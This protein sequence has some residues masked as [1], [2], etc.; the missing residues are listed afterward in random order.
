MRSRIRA[1]F[2]KPARS[3]RVV[4]V[5]SEGTSRWSK[6]FDQLAAV[7][8]LELLVLYTTNRA[9][10]LTSNSKRLHAS[11]TL[12]EMRLEMINRALGREYPVTWT[13]WRALL[14]L[15]PDCVLVFGWS[16]FAAQATLTWCN[17]L[18]I[19]YVLIVDRESQTGSLS[20]SQV[21]FS[22][23]AVRRAV[24]ILTTDSTL[25]AFQALLPFELFRQL[26]ASTEVASRD[27]AMEA[28]VPLIARALADRVL[29]A[30]EAS[31]NSVR[32][33]IGTDERVLHAQRSV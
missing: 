30:R 5:F 26:S 2:T 14:R 12:R 23:F 10:S 25:A 11:W 29:Q 17:L 13:I 22:R 18:R 32:T 8:G 19:P 9:P 28:L 21:R 20:L 15:R 6:V 7:N 3:A 27:R 33:D 24:G 16:T 1:T 31:S 4:A